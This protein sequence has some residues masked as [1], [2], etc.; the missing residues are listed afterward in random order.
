MFITSEIDSKN[1][2][3]PNLNDIKESALR[4]YGEANVFF[5]MVDLYLKDLSKSINAK[6]VEE[7]YDISNAVASD[8]AKC[9]EMYLKSI[10]IFENNVNVNNI[11]DIWNVLK[12]SSYKVDKNGNPIYL[13]EKNGEKIFTYV[14]VND[15]GKTIYIDDNNNI[16]SEGTQGRKIK[17]NGHQL[18]RLIDILSPETKI[19]LETR[20]CTIPI[21]NSVMYNK[22][23]LND[24]LKICGLIYPD[25]RMSRTDYHNF[26]DK[27]KKTFEEARYSGQNVSKV[28]LEF[29]YHLTNQIKSVAQYRI[30]P[31]SNQD[32]D[33]IVDNDIL[34]KNGIPDIEKILTKLGEEIKDSLSYKETNK[35][36]FIDLK[37]FNF[38]SMCKELQEFFSFDL[39]LLSEDLIELV[40]NNSDMKQKISFFNQFCSKS[41]L[42]E[43][44]NTA[45]YNL[46]KY[47]N[48]DEIKYISKLCG[49]IL[50]EF[51]NINSNFIN[52]YIYNDI[53][54]FF[55][56][57]SFSIDDIINYSIFIKNKYNLG[58]SD[59][60]FILYANFMQVVKRYYSEIDKI[61][62]D[63][64]DFMKL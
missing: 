42:K 20:M 59:D 15:E 52:D 27:H 9:C 58:I 24:V 39:R 23:S 19:L 6:S 41:M 1:S 32:F 57:Y 14:K 55:R 29:L 11:G 35:V 25:T 13:L 18:D 2:Y 63:E 7:I 31:T 51:Y 62:I 43:V 12:N 60:M 54:S 5:N 45:F 56:L 38:N 64:N 47:C 44:S 26:V 40:N 8:L 36:T 37:K 53:V 16:Y 48:E 49:F 3:V 61:I 22:V 30:C 46:I 34:I 10:Y 21:N 28:N 33:I 50:S 17:M 4:T